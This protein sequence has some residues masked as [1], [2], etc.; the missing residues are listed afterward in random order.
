MKNEGTKRLTKCPNVRCYRVAEGTEEVDDHAFEGCSKLEV[1]YLPYTMNNIAADRV[2]D[3]LPE[4]VGNVVHWDCPYVE[5]VLDVNDMWYDEDDIT[6]DEYGVKYTHGGRRL[7]CAPSTAQLQIGTKY[8][9]P[10]GVLTICDDAFI[11]RNYT[12][13]S[14]GKA[15]PYL[16]LSV[17]RSIKSIGDNIFGV[18]G[19]GGRIEIRD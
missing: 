6:T 1:L 8:I 12:Y 10:D 13:R 9:V 19:D 5:E 14:L 11:N 3:L 17:P 7:L 2:L 16:V 18:E 4:S 15:A